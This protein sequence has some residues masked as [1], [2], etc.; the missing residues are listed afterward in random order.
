MHD[1]SHGNFV[2]PVN[3][4]HRS[5]SS[6]CDAHEGPEVEDFVG[7]ICSAFFSRKGFWPRECP[8]VASEAH[9]LK[10]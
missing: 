5:K 2:F 1:D 3:V 10:F 4:C 8:S 6:N 7:T 9:L